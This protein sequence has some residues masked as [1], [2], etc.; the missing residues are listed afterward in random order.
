MSRKRLTYLTGAA[1]VALLV[2]GVG[3][4][5]RS[6]IFAPTTIT[7]YFV[8]AT[9]V[10]AGDEV[11]VAGVKV[12]LIKSIEPDGAQAK[13][14]LAVNHDVPIPAG[15]TAVIVA[16]NLISARYVQLAPA[17]DD[18]GPTM[19]DGAVIPVERTAVPVEWDEVKDQLTRLATE[20]GPIAGGSGT[21]VSHFID[22]AA[23]AMGGNGEKLRQTLTQLSGVGRILADGSG[24]IVNT[25][26][27]LATFIGTLRDSNSQIV[28]FQDRLAT[29][30]S[31]LDGSRSDLDSALRNVS[32]L[33]GGVQRFIR[34]SRNQTAEQIQRLSSVLQVVVDHQ[35]DLEQLLHVAPTAIANTLNFVDPRDGAIV[36]TF[37]FANFA[38]PMQ[39]I[40]G[41]IGAVE[42]ATATE[43]S[44]LCADYLGPALRALN[45]NYLPIPLNPFL[46]ATP[47]P[48]DLIYTEPGLAP[49]GAGPS[50]GP[51][52]TPP[53]VSAYTGLD[54]DVA[55]PPGY[56]VGTP[57][58]PFTPSDLPAMMLPPPPVTPPADVSSAP[59]TGP[60]L[61]AEAPL[62]VGAPSP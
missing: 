41:S 21:A 56:V 32:E 9:A 29:L 36:G 60:T 23:N 40:C 47:P 48:Q 1:L 45:F 10:Y 42:N 37:A 4:I 8:K 51:P 16:Q 26:K 18:S 28:Q 13:M 12:G 59:D 58:T 31:V 34:G 55:P 54:N 43:T 52:L 57:P 33:V 53:A 25:I 44:K 20:L 62:P 19:A 11:R 3:L 39:L 17:Y 2:A 35:K 50:P 49:G 61:P 15:A 46:A 27:N 7:A 22:S 38:N 14:T 24:N 30:T 6:T 5:I